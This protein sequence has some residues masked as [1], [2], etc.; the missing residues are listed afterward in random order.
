[1]SYRLDSE[2]AAAMAALAQRAAAGPVT[3]RGD[4]TTMRRLGE[5]GQAYLA[6]LTPPSSNVKTST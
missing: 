6:G 3:A 4:W 5:A 1:M 2:L